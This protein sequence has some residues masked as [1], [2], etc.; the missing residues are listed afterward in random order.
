MRAKDVM[1]DRADGRLFGLGDLL[2]AAPG[3]ARLVE[4]EGSAEMLDDRGVLVARRLLVEMEP[5]VVVVSI[6][7]F[8]LVDVAW[9]D[10]VHDR[11]NLS[12]SGQ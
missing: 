10:D 4:H 3:G 2:D 6:D 12:R 8:E 11:A 9:F 7:V 5:A 1:T